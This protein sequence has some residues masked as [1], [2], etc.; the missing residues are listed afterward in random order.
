MAV[1]THGDDTLLL[2]G[3]LLHTTPRITTP[4]NLSNHDEDPETAAQHRSTL[5]EAARAGA[6]TVAVS[7]FGSPFGRVVGDVG[8][9]DWSSVRA[10]A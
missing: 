6:W 2:T 5:V 8:A 9:L 7:H 10:R 3:D 4:T 1:L